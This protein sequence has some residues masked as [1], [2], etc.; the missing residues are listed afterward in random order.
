MYTLGRCTRYE[1]VRTNYDNSERVPARKFA[2][3]PYERQTQL[4]AEPQNL[5]Q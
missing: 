4:F 5:V 3:P 2:K 1:S